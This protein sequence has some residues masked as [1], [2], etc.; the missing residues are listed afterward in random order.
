MLKP[1][2][3]R[4]DATAPVVDG[5]RGP[6]AQPATDP[7]YLVE[8]EIVSKSFRLSPRPLDY[9]AGCVTGYEGR[10]PGEGVPYGVAIAAGALA[11]FPQTPYA[12]ALGWAL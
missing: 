5:T 10:E 4:S 1:N 6:I 8:P 7:V 2:D 3:W 9:R 11:T 12:A